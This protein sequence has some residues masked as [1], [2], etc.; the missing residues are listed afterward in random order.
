MRNPLKGIFIPLSQPCKV[1][2][3]NEDNFDTYIRL[4]VLDCQALKYKHQ[5]QDRVTS[6]D[7]TVIRNI[8]SKEHRGAIH[9][10]GIANNIIHIVV[11]MRCI[12]HNKLHIF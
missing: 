3:T 7:V 1:L 11:G 9:R 5:S 10:K 12:H 2:N 8:T 4:V 6:Y